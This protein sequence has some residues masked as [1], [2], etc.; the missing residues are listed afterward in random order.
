MQNAWVME[1]KG[2]SFGEGRKR[3]RRSPAWRR[4][5]RFFGIALL[6]ALFL[7][8]LLRE[9]HRLGTRQTRAGLLDAARAVDDYMAEHD[10]GCPKDL[11]TA[12]THAGM[13]SA[14]TD[15]WSRPLR[16]R[17]PGTRGDLTYELWSDGPDGKPGG[18][19]RIE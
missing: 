15:A 18:L 8:I 7:V 3:G 16:L 5:W 2:F 17:C 14:L 12:A 13:K 1:Q 6:A 19:D 11:E 4:G 9:Q 10:G